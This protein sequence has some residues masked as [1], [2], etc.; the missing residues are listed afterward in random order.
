M[1]SGGASE[2]RGEGVFPAPL[3]RVYFLQTETRFV[4]ELTFEYV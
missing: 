2:E 3:A 4:D 1:R